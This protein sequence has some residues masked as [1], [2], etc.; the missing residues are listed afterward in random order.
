MLKNEFQI[1]NESHFWN[2]M[3]Y[4]RHFHLKNNINPGLQFSEI[5]QSFLVP[6]PLNYQSDFLNFSDDTIFFHDKLDPR[7]F[8]K[9]V[10]ETLDLCI[11]VTN[12]VKITGH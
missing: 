10:D 5:C 7:R 8:L 3:T 6:N 9:M 4:K 12:P 2:L 11:D 1:N